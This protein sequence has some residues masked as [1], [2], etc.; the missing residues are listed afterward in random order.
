MILTNENF[1]LYAAKH[2][3]MKN[4]ISEEEFLD[5]LKRI[6]Y[7]KRLFKRYQENGDLKCRLILN[8]IIILRNCFGNE[9]VNMLFF[10]LSD[11]I[12]YL[13]TFLQYLQIMPKVV[14]IDGVY[15]SANSIVIDAEILAELRKI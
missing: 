12:E 4:S 7:I 14:C 5:D 8:H 10:R 6:Q 2:Y 15:L 11:Y 9:V 3:D 13:T 1:N